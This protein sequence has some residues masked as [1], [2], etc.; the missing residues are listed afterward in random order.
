MWDGRFDTLEKQ[1]LGPMSAPVEMN[2]DLKSI[3]AELQ[4]IPD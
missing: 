4:E 3:V 1:A 2:Q